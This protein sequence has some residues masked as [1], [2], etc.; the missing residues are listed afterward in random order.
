MADAQANN[1]G[2]ATTKEVDA[3]PA[4]KVKRWLAEWDLA[5]ERERTWREDCKKVWELYNSKDLRGSSFNIF[6][7]NTET[8]RP[9]IYNSTP[10]PDVRRRFRDA[11]P[12]GKVA[13]TILERALAFSIDEYDFDDE[14][15][16]VVLD[17]LIPGRG[18]ARIKY[19]PTFAPIDDA[20]TGTEGE[21]ETPSA[22]GAADADDWMNTGSD[23]E[24]EYEPEP[25]EMLVGESLETE[26]VLWDQFRMG[27]GKKWKQV[28]WVGFRHEMPYDQLCEMFGKECAQS[29]KLV[30][31]EKTE[32]IADKSIRSLM[33]VAVV[34]EIWDKATRT[35]LFINEGY[36]QGPLK[37][38]PDPLKLL[39]FLPM[40][41]PVYVIEDSTSLLPAILY[42]KYEPQAEELNRVSFRINKIV[43][44]LKVRGAYSAHLDEV[45][46]VLEAEDNVLI[47][48]QNASEIASMGGLD[49][50]IWM[51]PIDKLIQVLEGLYKARENTIQVIYQITGM[52]DVM[53]GVSNPHETLGAQQIKS[54]WGSMRLQRLQ[55]EIQRF[56][57]DLMRLKGEVISNFFQ[58][59]TLQAMTGIKLPTAQQKVQMQQLLLPPPQPMPGQMPPPQPSPVDKANAT[60]I[61]A[62]PTWE[63][64]M[65]LL[66]SDDMRQYRVEIETD[67]TIQ[68]TVSRDMD[69]MQKSIQAVVALFQGFAPAIQMGAI[70]IEVVKSLAQAV[71]RNAQMGQAVEDAIDQIVQPPP[72]PPPQHPPDFSLQVAQVKTASDQQVA[73]TQAQ[74]A[75][76]IA[77]LT[78]ATRVQVVQAELEARTAQDAANNEAK[79]QIAAAIEA[80]KHAIQQAQD[81]AKAER[82]LA[83]QQNQA[84]IVDNK[85][86]IEAAVSILV[87][88]IGATKSADKAVEP[89][90][91]ATFVTHEENDKSQQS[92]MDLIQQLTKQHADNNAAM[93]EQVAGLHA[94]AHAPKQVTLQKDASGRVTGAVATPV[95]PSKPTT[96]ASPK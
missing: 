66:K 82:E 32:N 79:Q 43:D 81:Q 39:G 54:Q 11:D 72:P 14:I 35:V 26:H 3:T 31:V 45:P 9:A 69:G 37:E 12:I 51:M 64:V 52:G 61:V 5:D 1:E 48:I 67:S 65:K 74:S 20:E 17:V 28:P 30:D 68:D 55:R 10:N 86:N 90:A 58:P 88:Q 50:A 40:P 49:K 84:M 16:N 62:L 27:A 59:E 85:T 94:A 21:G 19:K 71:A 46:K 77:K 87:A 25:D 60:K 15:K 34:Y 83:L 47:P 4:G 13:S 29:I 92:L 2:I 56:I 93:S 41:R 53:R 89:A 78:E 91:E 57:R 24:E 38:V 75:Q 33:K 23:A 95:L 73:Q 36:K 63:D 42:K 80:G 6:W 96:G 18:V 7:S 44:A 8:M 70:S 22:S 76:A